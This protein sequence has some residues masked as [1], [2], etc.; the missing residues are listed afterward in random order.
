[1]ISERETTLQALDRARRILAALET[2]KAG[3]TSL[4]LPASLMIELEDQQKIV[5]DL[6]GRVLG[7][8]PRPGLVAARP[9]SGF[10][11]HPA[12]NPLERHYNEILDNLVKGKVV[13]FLGPGINLGERG[14]EE[15]FA[16]GQH[17][18]TS[19]DL[20]NY[21]AEN[22]GYSLDDPDDLPKVSQYIQIARGYGELYDELHNLFNL[23]Y[24]PNLVHRF[25]GL[26]PSV[27]R[28]KGFSPRPLLFITSN[29]DDVLERA[30][31]EAG[32]EY[33]LVSYI[34]EGEQRGKFLHWPLGQSQSQLIERPN[35]YSQLS[36]EQRSVILK[37]HG[38]VDRYDTERDSYAI[39]EDHHINYLSRADIGS[40]MPYNLVAKLRKSPY[41]FLGYSLQD[42]RL[43]VVLNRL[44]PE[45][46]L[47]YK[48]W[49]VELN[50]QEL[51]KN[52]WMKWG[53]EMLDNPLADYLAGLGERLENLPSGSGETV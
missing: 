51:D 18:P 30:F 24:A 28:E 41:L 9:A 50:P 22:F 45:Q 4:D 53:V 33:D 44:W 14:P 13:I 17:L 8:G 26:L 20:A 3:Y 49:A 11:A 48:S 27:L 40:L 39:T 16:P 46:Q 42:W 7:F 21:L 29:Y 31:R 23:D 43:R 12:A 15:A 52:F 36:L 10:K 6:E 2:K 25:F 32:V 35:E 1:M 5:A 47:K 34:A 19:P 37:I 38:A